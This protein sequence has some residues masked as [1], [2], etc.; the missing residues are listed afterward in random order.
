MLCACASS[1][2]SVTITPIGLQCTILGGDATTKCIIARIGAFLILLSG[3]FCLTVGIIYGNYVKSRTIQFRCKLFYTLTPDQQYAVTA[4]EEKTDYTTKEIRDIIYCHDWKNSVPTPES[5]TVGPAI[6]ILFVLTGICLVAACMLWIGSYNILPWMVNDE[7]YDDQGDENDG[8]DHDRPRNAE[9]DEHLSERGIYENPPT[10]DQEAMASK[11]QC[12]SPLENNS[13]NKGVT[14]DN[15]KDPGPLTFIDTNTTE[16]PFLITKQNV[17]EKVN[18]NIQAN[19]I[20]NHQN[21]IISIHENNK[22]SSNNLNFTENLGNLKE[23]DGEFVFTKKQAVVMADVDG[24]RN[25][26]LEQLEQDITL[27]GG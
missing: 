9:G 15:R 20:N 16:P 12:Q 26:S 23:I 24:S 25:V 2:L 6:Y 5:F 18:S 22:N 21:Q 7:D 3:I 17:E 27:W 4:G 14:Q 1:L 19:L 10:K 11:N 13:L 8:D